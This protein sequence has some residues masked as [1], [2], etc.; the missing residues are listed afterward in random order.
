NLVLNKLPFHLF[1]GTSG[2]CDSVVVLSLLICAFTSRPRYKGLF[3]DDGKR[4]RKCLVDWQVV[5][6]KIGQIGIVKKVR[7][8]RFSAP[9]KQLS[10]V[11]DWTSQTDH[12]DN[13]LKS[14]RQS[15]SQSRIQN[16]ESP[17]V[18]CRSRILDWACLASS[19]KLSKIWQPRDEQRRDRFSDTGSH[20]DLRNGE[21]WFYAVVCH[22]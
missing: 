7:I 5:C 8:K 14:R 20:W 19:P 17:C 16:N 3:V 22:R 18:P 6:V 15:R 12:T 9:D 1:W 11:P 10:Q 13:R 21:W 4:E 2:Q